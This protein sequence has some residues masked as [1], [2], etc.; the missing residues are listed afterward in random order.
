LVLSIGD[1]TVQQRSAEVSMGMSRALGLPESATQPG[2]IRLLIRDDTEASGG[3]EKALAALAGDGA[4]ILVAGVD[5]EGARKAA[6]FAERASIPVVLLHRFD[7]LSPGD[8]TFVLGADFGA[9]AELLRRE[10]AAAGSAEVVAVGPGGVACTLQAP[11]AGQPR[12]PVYTWKRKRV[13]TLLL[14]GD[15]ACARAVVAE[16]TAARLRPHLGFGLGC[17][18]LFV[19]LET[20]LAKS[21]VAV[22]HFPVSPDS[23]VPVSMQEWR[24]RTGAP[25]SWHHTLGHDAALLAAAALAQFPLERVEDARKVAALHRRARD[26]LASATA[27]LWSSQAQ[28]FSGKRAL[29]RTP[30]VVSL[31][32]PSRGRP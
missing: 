30:R 32:Q 26:E 18:E 31:P 9:T 6:S 13:D 21:A 12:F 22:G 25:P 5:E 17:G 10:L 28:G 4:A 16:A 24:R 29:E 8:Y 23:N 3:L 1:S 2:A 15:G 20:K 27:A 7:G 19:S 11:A 14:T